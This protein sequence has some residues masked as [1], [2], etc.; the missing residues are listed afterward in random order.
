M[1]GGMPRTWCV[2]LVLLV[3]HLAAVLPGTHAADCTATSVGII[4]LTDMTVNDTYQG[5]SG[6]LYLGSNAP[7]PDHAADAQVWASS[8]EPLDAAGNP[9]SGGQIGFASIGM[10]NTNQE[11]TQLI[12]DAN[13]DP[14]KRPEVT[15][16]NCAQGGVAAENMVDITASFW[17]S[18]VPSKLSGAGLTAEQVQVVWLKQTNRGPTGPFPNWAQ[19][20]KSQFV[21]IC[22]NIQTTFPNIKVVYVSSR[23]YAGYASS[24]LNPEPYAYESGF[25]VKWLID[26]QIDGMTTLNHDPAVGI[27]KSGLLLWGPYLW[28]DGLTPNSQ[29]TTWLCPDDFKDDGT[30]PSDPEGRIKVSDLFLDFL[31]N[32]VTAFWYRAGSGS[33]TGV[34]TTGAGTTTGVATTGAGTTT[35]VATTGTLPGEQ[36]YGYG[37]NGGA[38]LADCDC[39]GCATDQCMP[40]NECGPTRPEDFGKCAGSW[41]RGTSCPPT[42]CSTTM[43]ATTGVAT[44]GVGTTGV[45]TTGVATTGVATTGVATTGVATTGVATTGVATTGVATTGSQVPCSTFNGNPPGC[46]AACYCGHC[47]GPGCTE[48]DANGPFSVTCNNPNQWQFFGPC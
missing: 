14:L 12:S 3:C 9:S 48:G 47:P 31:H 20:L 25:S 40:G 33:T 15:L 39:G 2:L 37:S 19:N 11:F 6:F 44:T 5:F 29:G 1:V 8:I 18:N 13:A 27:V 34:A 32:D 21:D 24:T 22:Q 35:G 45:A 26:D 46:R 43:G 10:S 30:H 17:S 38:C 41:N 36:C 4:P 16:V 7:P 23:I 42:G 28:A